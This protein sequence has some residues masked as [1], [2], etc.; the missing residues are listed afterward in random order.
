[1]VGL[2]EGPFGLVLRT[3]GFISGTF[4]GLSMSGRDTPRARE[5]LEEAR[6]LYAAD[7][8]AAI[9]DKD[10]E[11]VE[12]LKLQLHWHG[13]LIWAR[14]YPSDGQIIL[15]DEWG[16]TQELPVNKRTLATILSWKEEES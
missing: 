5:L 13:F 12:H 11:G 3:A 15:R 16:Q 9:W 6:K 7:N 14:L 8:R 1:M 4:H 2:H 10:R